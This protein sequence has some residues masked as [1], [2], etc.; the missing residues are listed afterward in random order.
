MP[1]TH[2]RPL[3]HPLFHSYMLS[4]TFIS[5]VF[6]LDHSRED[7]S[8]IQSA[9]HI[10]NLL[11]QSILICLFLY[12]RYKTYNALTKFSIFTNATANNV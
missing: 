8:F 5:S 10:Y 3:A 4:T 2:L 7:Q 11:V 9:M 6:H 1:S 12:F